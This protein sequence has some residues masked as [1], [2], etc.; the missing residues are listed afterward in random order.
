MSWVEG[1]AQAGLS[2]EHGERDSP[3]ASHDG[4]GRGRGWGGRSLRSQPVVVIEPVLLQRDVC[5]CVWGEERH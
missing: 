5:M 4:E 3:N 1:T 2:S